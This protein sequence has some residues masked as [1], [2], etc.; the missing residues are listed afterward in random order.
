MARLGPPAAPTALAVSWLACLGALLLVWKALP[1]R[2]SRPAAA[3]ALVYAAFAP[4][5]VYGYALFPLSLLA[6]VTV[7]FLMLLQRDRRLAAGIAAAVAVLAY[8]VGLAAAPAGAVWLLARRSAPLRDRLLGVVLVVAP[9]LA[10]LELFSLDQWLE[11]GRW[12]AYLLVQRKYDHHVQDPFHAVGSALSSA[13]GHGSPVHARE[14]A[15]TADAVRH[16]RARLRARRVALRRGP[17]ARADSLVAIWALAA[18]LIPH[19][20]ANVSEYRSEAALLPVALLV[21][22]LPQALSACIVVG[23]FLLVA[24]MELLFLRSVLV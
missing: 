16:L 9:S 1:V 11:T 4:G 22:R 24:P 18:W 8:P 13:F 14:R 21:G 15:R 5:I 12:N 23:A 6:L 17:R 19:I 2:D 10:A 3:I 7:A 20:W